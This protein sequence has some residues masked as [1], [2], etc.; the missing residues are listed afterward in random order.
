MN[1]AKPLVAWYQANKRDFPWRETR[2]PYAIWLSE[3]MLQQTRTTAVIPY[4][5]RFLAALPTVG[6]L[7]RVDEDALLRLWQGLGYY[8]RAR[9][10]QRAAVKIETEL[11]GAFPNTYEGLLA[12]PGVGPYTAGAIA[13]IAFGQ[14]VPAVDGNVLRVWARLRNCFDDITQTAVKARVTRELAEIMP[15]RA[16]DF[17]QALMELGAVVCLPIGAPRCESCP[18]RAF[19]K[20]FAAGTVEQLPVRTKKK[21]RKKERYT[22]FV[23]QNEG[24]FVVQKRPK[25]GLLASLYQLPHTVGFLTQE[26]IAAWLT[27]FGA[28][29]VG[30]L[31]VYSCTHIFTHIEWEM[32]V[33]CLEV[34]PFTPPVG[35][36]YDGTQGLPTAFAKC[37]P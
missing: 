27:A 33:V 11:G 5:E 19:C 12:L 2:D 6:D 24:S 15:Q 18:V 14:T 10:L 7:A 35:L 34:S 20:A 22:V 17:N 21:P 8:S 4:Y 26:E 13:S 1:F 37:L 23:L 31:A 28:R 3:I 36:W 16:G 29:P 9:N 32:R 25:T 30:E